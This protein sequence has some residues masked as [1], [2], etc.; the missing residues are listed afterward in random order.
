MLHNGVIKIIDFGVA[1]MLPKDG[2]GLHVSTFIVPRLTMLMFTFVR[3][4]RAESVRHYTWR[5]RSLW[6]LHNTKRWIVG[7]WQF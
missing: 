7:P 6:T 1:D 5:P 4:L 2:R 3:S